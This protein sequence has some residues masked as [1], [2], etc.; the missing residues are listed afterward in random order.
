MARTGVVRPL[1]PPDVRMLRASTVTQIWCRVRR[2]GSTA[3]RSLSSSGCAMKVYTGTG[4][5][6]QTSLFNGTRVPK[7]DPRVDAYGT[8]D[9]CNA[10]VGLACAHLLHDDGDRGADAAGV[11]KLH[12][13]LTALQHKLFD[14]GAHLATPRDNS[15]KDK[16]AKTAFPAK[17]AD[18]LEAWIDDMEEDLAPL[19]TFILPGGHPA[20]AALH[21]ARTVARRAERAVTPMLIGT[22]IDPEPDAVDPAAYRFMNRLSDFFF[23]ASRLANKLTNNADVTWAKQSSAP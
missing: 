21:L 20:A 14:L 19:T 13:R 11:H 18:D 7:H 2:E 9:E 16:L 6:G 17:A 12:S 4:D 8:V 22:G 1:R 23:V 10:A 15:S 5:A 3:A